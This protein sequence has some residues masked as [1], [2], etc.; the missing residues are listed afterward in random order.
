[1]ELMQYLIYYWLKYSCKQ[2]LLSVHKARNTHV[3]ILH[4]YRDLHLVSTKCKSKK[5]KKNAYRV[6]FTHVN[7]RVYIR[8]FAYV[9][10]FAYTQ[11]NP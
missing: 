5:K 9:S 8:Q 4:I 2:I 6:K 1:M 11:I 3:Q 7:K 10:K